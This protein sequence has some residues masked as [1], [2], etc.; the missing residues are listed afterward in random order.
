MRVL[1]PH[2]SLVFVLSA[3]GM[4]VPWSGTADSL[5]TVR[6][7]RNSDHASQPA[8]AAGFQRMA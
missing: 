6:Q 2:H 5:S 8:V 4:D 7:S 1:F 3:I